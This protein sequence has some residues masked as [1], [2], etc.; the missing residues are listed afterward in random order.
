MSPRRARDVGDDES[1]RQI[2]AN[3]IDAGLPGLAV[4]VGLA[5][6]IRSA[7]ALML[8]IFGLSLEH[9]EVGVG[10]VLATTDRVPEV[11]ATDRHHLADTGLHGT[12]RVVAVGSLG[13]LLV[14]P[15]V[16]GVGHAL[17]ILANFPCGAIGVGGAIRGGHAADLSESTSA[18]VYFCRAVG[19]VGRESG[20]KLCFAESSRRHAIA[21]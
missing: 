18:E 17:R 5:C 10:D 16:L 19:A 3:T 12:I 1:V 4:G 14:H 8:Q 6:G 7:L 15:A 9:A 13:A 21:D 11:G 20:V 2:V